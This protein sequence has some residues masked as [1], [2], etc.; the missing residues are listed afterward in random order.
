MKIEMTTDDYSS[1]VD[2]IENAHEF[3]V[4]KFDEEKDVVK[5]D[6]SEIEKLKSYLFSAVNILQEYY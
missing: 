2:D 5:L 4:S 6:S 1:V 3:T